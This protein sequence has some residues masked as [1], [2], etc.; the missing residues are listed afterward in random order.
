MEVEDV[1][2][3]VIQGG[4][5]AHNCFDEMKYH[6]MQYPIPPRRPEKPKPKLAPWPGPLAD[7][8]TEPVEY[9]FMRL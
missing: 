3:F 2:N 1:H 9:G 4:V 7:E 6:L 8:N 5:V